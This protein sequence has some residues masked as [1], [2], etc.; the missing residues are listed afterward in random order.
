MTR[1]SSSS[2]KAIFLLSV[3]GL[4]LEMML[5]RWVSTELRIFAYLQNT[6]LVVCFLGLGMG[7]WSCRRPVSARQALIPLLGIVAILAIPS[8]RA[9][10]QGVTQGFTLL[11][12]YLVWEAAGSETNRER[13]IKIGG[14]ILSTLGLMVMLWHV[15]LPQG[16][17]LGRLLD[18]DQR[19][20]R[21]YSINVAG[22][23]VGIGLFV[24]LSALYQPPFVWCAVAGL[25]A[26]P[27]LNWRSGYEPVM[28]AGVLLLAAVP[29]FE[30]E[31][32]EVIWSP[33]QKLTYHHDGL[34]S[35]VKVN[36]ANYFWLIDL[37]AETIRNNPDWYGDLESRAGYY[38]VPSLLKPEAEQALIV[39]SGGGNDVAGLVRGGAKRIVAVEIDPAIIDIGRRHH[40]ERPYADPRVTVVNDDARAFFARSSEQFDLIVFGLLDA[41]TTTAMMNARLDHFVYTRES[42]AQVKRLLKDDGL[43]VLC[44]EAVEPYQIARFGALLRESF[45]YVGPAFRIKPSA[46]GP[47]GVIFMAANRLDPVIAQ[48]MQDV[49]RLRTTIEHGLE[50]VAGDSTGPLPTDDWPYLYLEKPAI[51]GLFAMLTA[52][53][54]ALY[55]YGATCLNLPLMPHRSRSSPWHFFFMGAAFL[56]LETSNIS[57]AAVVLGNTWD[58]NAVIVAAILIFILLANALAAVWPRLPIGVAWAGLLGSCIAM[59][60]TD[61]AA[62]NEFPF[63]SR[64]I[65]VGTLTCLPVFFA[66]LVFVRSFAAVDAKDAALGANLLGAL[67]GGLLQALT[68][69]IG[70][71]AILLVVAGLYVAALLARPRAFLVNRDAE[72]LRSVVRAGSV[73]DGACATALQQ[74]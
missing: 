65:L 60:C 22:S 31:A 69:L 38:D 51:P 64:S 61:L 35:T 19:T 72:A 37:R 17:L 53:M 71:K 47:G 45:A 27:F 7:C 43:V 30:R 42:F 23:L 52:I 8:W 74:R 3:L 40:P 21:A 56:L 57:R 2:G 28:L 9:W 16:R 36:N 12:D 39:G 49:P 68:F 63:V 67:A 48:R 14:A 33:Y 34:L 41:H 59:Y 29:Q 25:L 44:F 6:V 26:L 54:L 50:T 1:S 70:V 62:F 66:G 10:M 55:L 13:L 11:R 58:V 20:V 24:V 15:F 46:Y 32:D 5:I 73:S 4:F 18:D